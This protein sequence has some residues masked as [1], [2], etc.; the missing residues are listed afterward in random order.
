VTGAVEADR[1]PTGAD[2]RRVDRALQR[3]LQRCTARV[4]SGQR[5]RL[6]RAAVDTE[7]E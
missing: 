7:L 3:C 4:R 2:R 6:R 1:D 5:N